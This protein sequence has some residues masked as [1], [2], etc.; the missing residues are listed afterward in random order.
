MAVFDPSEQRICVRVVYDGAAGAGKT[1]N[2]RQL[3]GH[4]AAQRTTEVSSPAELRGRTLY[5]DWLQI[6]AGAVCGFPLICQV[7][8]VPGQ[9]AF[10]ARRRHLLAAADV[11]VFVCDSSRSAVRRALDALLLADE[12]ILPTGE[13]MPVV[14]QANKQDRV[15]AIDGKALLAA[16]QRPSVHVV[17]AIATEGIGVLDTFVSAVRTAARAIQGRVDRDELRIPVRRAEDEHQLLAQ[18]ASVPI[19]RY[20]AAELLLEEASAACLME[21]EPRPQAIVV[22]PT[23][24][25]RRPAES[26]SVDVAPLPNAEVPTGFIWPAHTGRAMLR[27]LGL[28]EVVEVG[29][30][31]VSHATEGH[32]LST[33]LESCF[34]DPDAARQ[35]L[36]R[37]ARE[38]TQL[39]SLLVSDTVLVVQPAESGSFWL[40]TVTPRTDLVAKWLAHDRPTR[41]ELLGS[42]IVSAV[43]VALRH[44][45]AFTPSIHAFGVQRGSVRYA[46]ATAATEARVES[47]IAL[48]LG[49]IADVSKIDDADVDLFVEVL[50]RRIETQLSADE[51]AAIAGDCPPAAGLDGARARLIR[52]IRRVGEAA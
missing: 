41:T 20:G 1:T 17:E 49:A 33:S 2:L 30:S 48:L 37:A 3:G 36:V 13:P 40:W 34:A 16:V 23:D 6:A 8:S 21:V 27:T 47:A 18:V 26:G 46:G 39:E 24:E 38:R 29:P 35:A 44:G 4:F 43:S 22:E 45:L 14:I 52:T 42:A 50:E 19:D 51:I 25:R 32:V 9:A 28:D 12:L 31:G 11:V 7:I 10:T 15:D 5:F